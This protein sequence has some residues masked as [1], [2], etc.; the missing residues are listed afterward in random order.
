MLAFADVFGAVLIFDREFWG[1]PGFPWHR[2]FGQ[3]GL[4]VAQN[5]GQIYCGALVIVALL[6]FGV[7]RG[8]LWDRASASSP[9]RCVLCL[10]YALGWYTPAFF[11]D[12]RVAAGRVALPQA[13]GRHLRAVRA[14]GDDRWLS[15]APQPQ[16]HDA[17]RA[18][19]AARRRD[20]AGAGLRRHS[21]WAR[22]SLP[23]TTFQ[24]VPGVLLGNGR[25]P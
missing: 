24:L 22:T 2:A 21:H 14:A 12:V 1:P 11:S 17:G 20:C 16:R 6:G 25:R 19:A 10:L 23:I 9:S 7:A 5:M 8:Q 18:R 4:Y 13:G 15:R 3:T